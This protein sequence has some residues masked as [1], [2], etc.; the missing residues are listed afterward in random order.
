MSKKIMNFYNKDSEK[1]EYNRFSSI[2]GKYSDQ[3]HKEIVFGFND[4]W[5]NKRILDVCCGTG[6]FSIEVAK[7]GARVTSLDFSREMLNI[8]NQKACALQLNKNIDPLQTDVHKMMFK[9]DTFDGCICITAI[10]LI[11]DYLS[12]IREI[13]RVLKPNG[14]LIMNFPNLLGWY[15]PIGMYVNMTKKSI[16]KDVHSKWFSIGEIKMAF[17]NAGLGITDIKGYICFPANT[18]RPIFKVLRKADKISRASI[19]KYLSASL[20]V[21]GVKLEVD[22]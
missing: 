4:S 17:S 9:D 1:Y 22:L 10:Q 15:F 7:K 21:K 19:L 3:V 2:A 8:L 14:F 13:S 18:P 6:R 12:V 5:N 16:Q 11:N 20:F